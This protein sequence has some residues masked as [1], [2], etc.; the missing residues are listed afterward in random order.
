MSDTNPWVDLMFSPM[1]LVTVV[2][3]VA[4]VA[5][6]ASDMSPKTPAV[7][8][9]FDKKTATPGELYSGGNTATSKLE[10][11]FREALEASGCRLHPQGTMIVTYP[12]EYGRTHKYTP[13]LIAKNRK[14]I[15][16]IDPEFTHAGK[17]NDDFARGLRYQECG[18]GV[19]RVRLGKNLR[20]LGKYDVVAPREDF[21]DDLVPLIIS[22]IKA[23][24]P[25]PPKHRYGRY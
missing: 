10:M 23:A 1:F 12:D 11:R 7:K 15:V 14:V 17:E 8:D 19:V 22:R 21:S 16:E 20:P 5:V 9:N 3:A 13:D 6:I 18:Y 2:C 4:L 24:R 25:L